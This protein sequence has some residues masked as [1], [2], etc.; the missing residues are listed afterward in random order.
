MVQVAQA[1]S[2]TTGRDGDVFEA[3]AGIE[4]A[5]TALRDEITKVGQVAQQI[6]AIAKQTNLLA[7]NATIEAARAGE[8]GKGF[9]VVAGEVK[10]LAGQTSNATAEIS[11][12]LAHLTEQ[13]D[14]L[15]TLSN[16]ARS[17]VQAMDGS[18]GIDSGATSAPIDRAP[19]QAPSAPSASVG[20][21]SDLTAE[22]IRLIRETFSQVEPFAEDTARLFY[23]C[24]FIIDPTVKSLF[25]N[26]MVQQG[27]ALM[28]M[29]K[30]AVDGLDDLAAL[31]PAVQEL[32][33]HHAAYGVEERH[34]GAVGEALITTLKDSLGVSIFN[35]DAENAWA[36]L[37][38]IVSGVMISAGK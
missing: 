27:R 37:Y 21:Q 13:T 38:G 34:Y 16:D 31:V 1:G 4:K 17:A 25:K 3:I 7:L 29:I 22:E 8:A 6:D 5:L 24:L 19:A 35:R 15:E 30:T 36:K 12:T 23:D 14:T 11:A 26:D 2:N 9:A 33:V 10:T 18:A 20:D 32:G 28:A